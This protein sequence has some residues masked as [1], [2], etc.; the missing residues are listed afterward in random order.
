MN[1][2]LFYYKKLFHSPHSCQG[3]LVSESKAF[4]H[5]L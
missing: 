5:F 3:W 2:G 1:A 4:M